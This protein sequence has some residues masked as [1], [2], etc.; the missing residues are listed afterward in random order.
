MVRPVFLFLNFYYETFLLKTITVV[1]TLLLEDDR[2][3]LCSVV[4]CRVV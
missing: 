3:M 4:Q 2:A 1:V